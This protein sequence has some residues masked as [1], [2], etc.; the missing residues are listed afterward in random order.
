MKKKNV[1][2]AKVSSKTNTF[3][4][5]EEQTKGLLAVILV[6]VIIIGGFIG[7]EYKEGK[8][9][10]KSYSSEYVPTKDEKEFKESYEELNGKEDYIELKIDKNNNVNIID[11]QKA[12]DIID[13]DTGVILFGYPESNDARLAV[14]S[15]LQAASNSGLDKFNYVSLKV[16]G[17]D[18]RDL[19]VLNKKNKAEVSVK[20]S[21]TYSKV[22]ISLANYLNDYVLVT[23][24]GKTVSTGEKRLE[25]GTVV[26]VKD[27][28]VLGVVIP[29]ENSYEDL[30]N[31]DTNLIMEYNGEACTPTS[32]C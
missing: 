11:L 2:E 18:I 31:K 25:D 6:I 9:G 8:I 17:N 20:A 22:L 5:K 1:K 16:D 27:G 32:G 3:K 7:Y 28:E 19:F 14:K 30:V 21:E 15:L 4:L 13:G 26:F 24:S 12:S 23:D 29:G 10:K